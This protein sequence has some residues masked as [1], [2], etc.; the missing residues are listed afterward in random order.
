MVT[1][2][3]NTNLPAEHFLTALTQ[4]AC[5]RTTHMHYMAEY[6]SMATYREKGEEVREIIRELKC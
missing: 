4:S 3:S 1:V 6:V 5:Q 2:L